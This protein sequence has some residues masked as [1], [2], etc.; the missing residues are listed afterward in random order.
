MIK[1]WTLF[2][3]KSVQNET[4]LAM[5][6]LTI[7]SGANSSGKSTFLQSILLVAQTLAHKVSSRSVVLNGALAQLGQFDDLK[8]IDSDADQIVIGWECEPPRE[9]HNL[10]LSRRRQT[11]SSIS[12]QIAF[13][14]KGSEAEREIA[15]IQPL[16]FSSQ[17][18]VLTRDSDTG[19]NRF[20]MTIRRAEDG[21]KHKLI[22][23]AN[24]D[25]MHP[26][27]RYDVELDEE[28][29]ADIRSEFTSAQAVGCLLRH[30]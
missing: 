10:G 17:L 9:H 18:S 3:F 22:D 16:L 28:S 5:A 4:K 30:F 6:P 7:F 1:Q 12:C 21:S 2:N 13:D 8:S 19:G 23:A 11:L 14:T 20:S 25:D 15:Q 27:L 24:I 26:G 29:L